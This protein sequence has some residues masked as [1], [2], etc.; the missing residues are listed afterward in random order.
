MRRANSKFT[1]LYKLTLGLHRYTPQT[2]REKMSRP[3]AIRFSEEEEKLIEEFLAK[4]PFFDFTS[5]GK[6]AIL[7]FIRKPT[8]TIQP[9]ADNP[10][11]KSVNDSKQIRRPAHGHA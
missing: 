9:I 5:L 10:V 4:N 1:S 11:S 6:V 2:L 8:V 7:N 3:R